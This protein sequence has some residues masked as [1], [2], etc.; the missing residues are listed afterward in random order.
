MTYSRESA[1]PQNTSQ[2]TSEELRADI[3]N[4]RNEMSHKL[5]AIQEQFQ[6]E[7]LR[8]Q[9]QETV[10]N[11]VDDSVH[12]MRQ[13]IN[14]NGQ[15]IGASVG[16]AIKRHPLPAALVGIGLGWLLIDSM[17]SDSDTHGRERRYYRGGDGYSSPEYGH[18]YRQFE[19]AQM[20]G[21]GGYSEEYIDEMDDN[22]Y[23]R[24]TNY[25]SG[26]ERRYGEQYPGRYEDANYG[27]DAERHGS[28]S[29]NRQSSGSS[30]EGENGIVDRVQDAARSAADTVQQGAQSAI[31]E[32][33]NQAENIADSAQ[34]YTSQAGHQSQRQMD[35]WGHQAEHQAQRVRHQAEYQAQRARR[36]AQRAGRQAYRT[37]EDN[38]LTFGVIALGIGAAIGLALPETRQ[39]DRLL[40]DTRDR[41]FDAAQ[42]AAGDVANRAQHVVE[43]VRPEVEQTAQKVADDLK[44]AGRDAVNDLKQTGRESAQAVK[45]TAKDAADTAQSEAEGAKEDVKNRA[46]NARNDIGDKVTPQG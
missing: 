15:E 30:A 41:V 1:F 10:R 12:S 34:E 21:L 38:P 39:E 35:Q 43:E 14:D 19:R 13:Y 26:M 25:G 3:D 22:V 46:E 5:D 45:E 4:K 33:Q 31:N 6:P 7:R 28:A 9:A 18:D 23:R 37:I 42:E 20:Y 29:F 40:G 44:E 36:Q 8:E 32:V 11:V 24:S 27:Y 16:R 2:E 17:S